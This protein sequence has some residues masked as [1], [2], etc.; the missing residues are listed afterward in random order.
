[1]TQ[2]TMTTRTKNELFY[3]RAYFAEAEWIDTLGEATYCFWKKLITRVDR[4]RDAQA[5][6][7]NRNTVP[8]SLTRLAELMGMTV[9]TLKKHARILWNAG[10]VDFVEW[11]AAYKMGKKPLNIVVYNYPQNNTANATKSLQLIRNYDE[12]YDA[13]TYEVYVKEVSAEIYAPQVDEEKAPTFTPSAAPMNVPTPVFYDE[14]PAEIPG[15]EYVDLTE[16]Y[17]AFDDSNH[18][19]LDT[20]DSQ[21]FDGSNHHSFD[22]SIGQAADQHKYISNAFVF[23]NSNAELTTSNA[24]NNSNPVKLSNIDNNTY[25]FISSSSLLENT[26]SEV[27]KND[28]E[29]NKNMYFE[30]D[31][32]KDLIQTALETRNVAPTTINKVI[33]HVLKENVPYATIELINKQLDDMAKEVE[34]G[35]TIFSFEKYFVNGLLMKIETRE[36]Y[37]ENTSEKQFTRKTEAKKVEAATIYRPSGLFYDW[38]NEREEMPIPS[39]ETIPLA[40]EIDLT[41]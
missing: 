22:R 14:A 24:L 5:K 6:Y 37:A 32:L 10:L 13:G 26:S 1:M 2:P 17:A 33:K 28:E 39:P 15:I 40:A 27:I 34:A 23:N 21:S 30:R 4:S 36:F 8:F 18:Q 11:A 35:K 41:M 20:T 31:L 3:Q 16:L 7:G 19:N 38:L 12:Q 25:D 9:N 29:E